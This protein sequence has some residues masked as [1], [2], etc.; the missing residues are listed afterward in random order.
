VSHT[1]WV[2]IDRGALLHNVRALRERVRP[3]A[4]MG[5]VKGNAYGHGLA[6]VA[7][8]LRNEVDWLGV[9]SLAEAEQVSA[10]APGP[11]VLILGHTPLEAAAAVVA[12]GYRQV[13]YDEDGVDALA[14]AAAAQGRRTAVHLKIETGTNRLGVRPEGAA[15][16]AERIRA[17][18][19]LH[20]EGIYTHFA[21]VEDAL[22]SSFAERQLQRFE[23]AVQAVERG[24]P[25]PLHH[26][27]ATAA[28][29]M[30]PRTHGALARTGIGLYGLWPSGTTESAAAAVGLALCL[31]PVLTWKT[32]V[33]HVKDVPLGETIGYGC[34]YYASQPRR[35]A[36][37]PVGYY[38]GFDR[39]LSSRGQEG[40]GVVLVR[41]CPATV[42][43]RVAM[44]MSMVDVTRIP[45][46]AVGDEVVLIGRQGAAAIPAELM[47]ERLETI[48][49][50]V[51]TRI[52]ASVPRVVVG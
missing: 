17:H 52:A 43:G 3:A 20:L 41:G 18:P 4:L 46:V 22:D 50:E 47:A 38:E 1:T 21:N 15:T 8:L 13:V 31:R 51:V 40:G 42:L 12:G 26:T 6:E 36:V 37:L 30:Y 7:P 28:A 34:A 45:E 25:V 14:V 33:A 49:Y 32:R 5:V 35:I 19:A 16:L 2:E 27:A 24:G 44:N 10:L 23:Q 11:P 9:N 48:N 39:G 29:I